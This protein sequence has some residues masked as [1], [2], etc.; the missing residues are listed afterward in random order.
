M[1][2]QDRYQSHFGIDPKHL[3]EKSTIRDK[4]PNAPTLRSSESY[5][6]G[7]DSR[8]IPG[9]SAFTG[10]S[11]A[12]QDRYGSHLS[13]DPK[14]LPDGSSLKDKLPDFSSI[15][16]KF[17]DQSTFRG[18]SGA[19]QDRYGSHLGIDSKDLPD[20]SSIRDKLP[21]LSSIRDKLP[22]K[23]TFRGTSGAEQDRYGSHFDIPSRNLP[24]NSTLRSAIPSKAELR[25]K[26]PDLNTLKGAPGA[27]QDRYSSHFSI[28]GGSHLNTT[29]LGLFQSTILPSFGL[30]SGLSLIAY[31]IARSTNRIEVKDLIWPTAAL[32]NAWYSAIGSTLLTSNISFSAA[33]SRLTYTQK[34]LLGGI[35][36]WAGRSLYRIA[37]RTL[38]R[39]ADSPSN[40]KAKRESGFWENALVKTFLPEA[41]LQTIVSLP[42]VL[43]FRAPW[44]SAAA[45]P[46]LPVGAE[47]VHGTAVFLFV[48]GMAIDG[49]ADAQLTERADGEAVKEDG[50]SS[51]VRQPE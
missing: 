22:D 43:P 35:T 47:L 15:R 20:G 26:L 51:I 4:L 18:S 8:H 45:S 11:G 5:W 39:D 3:P 25:S 28:H 49:A 32:A 17:P 44:A 41:V 27:G 10:T 2:E 46:D 16:D 9:S 31:G 19:E 50:V 23:S 38:T 13:V 30:H 42:F 6:G 34:L 12:E 14:N 37:T 48:A 33:V 1:A 24:D 7:Y 21:D 36:L 29:T 40:E